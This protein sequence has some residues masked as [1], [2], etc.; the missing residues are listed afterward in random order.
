MMSCKQVARKVSSEEELPLIQRVELR[1]H[2]LKCKHCSN[3]VKQ[4][5]LMKSGFRNLFRKLDEVE[6]SKI[7]SLEKKILE[8]IQKPKD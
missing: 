8:K 6:D 3:Y 2:L 5:E 4:L 1:M 7:R